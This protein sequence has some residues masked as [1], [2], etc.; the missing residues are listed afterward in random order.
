M[1]RLK[2][3]TVFDAGVTNPTESVR[4]INDQGAEFVSAHRS[5]YAVNESIN[6]VFTNKVIEGYKP[7]DSYADGSVRPGTVG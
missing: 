4:E 3:K 5:S 7:R 6:L 2:Q 1:G